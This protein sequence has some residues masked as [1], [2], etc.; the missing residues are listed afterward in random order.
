MRSG[1]VTISPWTRWFVIVAALIS[2]GVA[3]NR[4]VSPLDDSDRYD[5]DFIQEYLVSQAIWEGSDPYLPLPQ[6]ASKYLEQ[7]P[8]LPWKHPSPHPPVAAL[9]F[10]PVGILPYWTGKTVWLI[11]ELACLFGF[12]EMIARW[13]GGGATLLTKGIAVLACL[14][15]GP[16]IRELWNG[17]FSL[18]LLAILTGAWL[19]LRSGRDVAGGGLL[20]LSIALKLTGWPIALFLGL[21]RRWRSAAACAGVIVVTHLLAALVLG[22]DT[23]T[24]YYR[25]IGPEVARDYRQHMENYSFWSVGS[26]LFGVEAIEGLGGFVTEPLIPSAAAEKGLTYVLPVV[27]LIAAMA[28]AWRCRS[29]DSAYGI[30]LVAGLPINPVVWDHYLLLTALPIAI[31]FRRLSYLEFPAGRVTA[32]MIGLALSIVLPHFYLD[33]MVEAFARPDAR[34]GHVM[35]FWPGLVTYIPLIPLAI[36]IGLLWTTDGVGQFAEASQADQSPAAAAPATTEAGVI[37]E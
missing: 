4:I 12:V 22:L 29:F 2:A 17:Q 35:P 36:W 28:L 24:H 5:R 11:V 18:I 3:L 34:Y 16:M 30:L 6:M 1:T 37:P 13:W 9:A 33:L 26:R 8:A 19:G 20:G 7:P 21:R 31:C 27:M 10:V 14:C 32:A 15:F 23:V 25:V